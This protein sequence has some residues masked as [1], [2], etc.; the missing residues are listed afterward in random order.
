MH[1]RVAKKSDIP[2]LSTL[3]HET[4]LTHGPEHYTADQ[5]AAWAASTLDTEQ[6]EAFILDVQTYVAETTA[7]IVGFSGLAA[8]G[9]VASLYVRQDCLKQGIGSALLAHVIEQAQ[10]DRRSRLYAEASEFSL[11]LFQKFGFQQYDTEIV[12][13]FGVS[14]T[15]YLMEKRI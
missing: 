14:F 10:R 15:R 12:E 1:M 9:H 2:T 11:G 3:F 8:D 6:F 4:V 13:R 5:T 7:G